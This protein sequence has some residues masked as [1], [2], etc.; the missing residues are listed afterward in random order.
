M[1]AP[2]TK[3]GKYCM[4]WG[5][6]R[7]LFSKMRCEIVILTFHLKIDSILIMV[8]IFDLRFPLILIFICDVKKSLNANNVNY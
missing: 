6:S 7:T 8:F 3:P 2:P 4:L 1:A 5:T